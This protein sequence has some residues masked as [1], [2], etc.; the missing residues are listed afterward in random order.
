MR[1]TSDQEWFT[2]GLVEPTVESTLAQ[3]GAAPRHPTMAEAALER[4]REAIILGEL[5]AGTP[6]RLEDLARSLG[7]S[8]SPIREA[9][10][11][12]RLSCR[13]PSSAP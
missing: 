3:S 5:T 4:L 2:L 7:M 6:L 12:L 13:R 1:L 11:R 10:R 9:V 8:I